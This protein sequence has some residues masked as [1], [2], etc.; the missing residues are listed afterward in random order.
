M[1]QPR[2][3]AGRARLWWVKGVEQDFADRNARIREVVQGLD[4]ALYLLIEAENGS[5]LRLR[6]HA[7]RLSASDPGQ[8]VGDR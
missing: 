7:D 2:R 6:R 5:L 4:G 3:Q 1:K 8:Q